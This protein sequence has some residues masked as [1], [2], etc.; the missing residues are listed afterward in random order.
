MYRY[1]CLSFCCKNKARICANN[2]NGWLS[3]GEPRGSISCRHSVVCFH[4]PFSVSVVQFVAVTAPV[5]IVSERWL[6]AGFGLERSYFGVFLFCPHG[7]PRGALLEVYCTVTLRRESSEEKTWQRDPQSPHASLSQ[8]VCPV[9]TPLEKKIDYFLFC[10]EH[11]LQDTL[12]LDWCCKYGCL[13][14]YEDVLRLMSPESGP[15]RMH[16]GRDGLNESRRS[17]CGFAW[18]PLEGFERQQIYS[19]HSSSSTNFIHFC[20]FHS[21]TLHLFRSWQTETM[22]T[23]LLYTQFNS[24]NPQIPSAGLKKHVFFF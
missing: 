12:F 18:F 23:A 10:K 22:F 4:F 24:Q 17:W 11:S 21:L 20:F 8:Y 14:L 13:L 5:S 6:K 3:E 15:D 19:S 1:L 16:V 9:G 7:H 2:R